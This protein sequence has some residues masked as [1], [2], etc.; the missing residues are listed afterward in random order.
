VDAYW[1]QQHVCASL[2]VIGCYEVFTPFRKFVSVDSLQ[3]VGL[4]IPLRSI[5]KPSYP[6]A[7]TNT[8]VGRKQIENS[9][10]KQIL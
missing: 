1:R 6:Q 2:R 8:N 10:L 4:N 9:D 5:F 3:L 7:G